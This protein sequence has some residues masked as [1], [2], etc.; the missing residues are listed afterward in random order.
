MSMMLDIQTNKF[1]REAEEC[2]QNA[3]QAMN[4]RDR[5]AWLRLADD[6]MKLAQSDDLRIEIAGLKMAARFHRDGR[7]RFRRRL[8]H[9]WRCRHD[10]G[11]RR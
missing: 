5:D 8:P 3:E 4:P 10:S 6:W 1:R 2:R 11:I 9:R 7:S